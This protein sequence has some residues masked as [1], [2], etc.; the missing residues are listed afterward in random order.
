[1]LFSLENVTDAISIVFSMAII[2]VTETEKTTETA[3]TNKLTKFECYDTPCIVHIL[4]SC[5]TSVHP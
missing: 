2:I 1:M 5:L 3:S 4:E